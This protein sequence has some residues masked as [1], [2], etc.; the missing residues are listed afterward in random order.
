MT[1]TLTGASAWYFYD[2]DLALLARVIPGKT[3][4]GLEGPVPA[5]SYVLVHG[6]PFNTIQVIT[7]LV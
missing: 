4:S 7:G 3:S 6:S 5:G 2:Q 1:L